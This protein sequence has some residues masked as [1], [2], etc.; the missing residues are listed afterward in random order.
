[1]H[2]FIYHKDL[3]S[4]FYCTGGVQLTLAKKLSMVDDDPYQFIGFVCMHLN[5][6]E[7]S[8]NET[9]NISYTHFME[10]SSRNKC[11]GPVLTR[12][13]CRDFIRSCDI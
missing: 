9:I 2:Y 12:V 1:M 3:K 10:P 13:R 6:Y 7:I 4:K 11:V 5:H 8:L